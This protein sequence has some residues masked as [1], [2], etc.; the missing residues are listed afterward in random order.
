MGA[1]RATSISDSS[2]SKCWIFYPSSRI[3][4]VL[5][6]VLHNYL[7]IVSYLVGPS[8][9]LD[10]CTDSPESSGERSERG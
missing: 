3:G 7:L 10:P 4:I 9:K 5:R 8:T 2:K 1:R 6:S